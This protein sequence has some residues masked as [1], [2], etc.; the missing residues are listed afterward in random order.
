MNR[1]LDLF[2]N[3]LLPAALL[4]TPLIYASSTWAADK[5]E[6][7]AEAPTE[8]SA[9]PEAAGEGANFICEADVFFSWKRTPPPR[10]TTDAQGKT[11]PVAVDPELLKPIEE[12]FTKVGESG[13]IE[14]DVRNRLATRL[15]GVELQAR[16][17]C[18]ELHQDRVSCVSRN[19]RTTKSDYQLLDFAA[20][21]ALLSSIERECEDNTGVCLSTRTGAITCFLNTPPDAA[22]AGA[23][24]G[25]S[26]K[27][28][29]KKK[30]KK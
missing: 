10:T 11:V 14:N 28:S 24:G 7:T 27:E 15:G 23:A 1:S 3:L 30:G 17:S 4:L 19:L 18:E 25:E 12:F 21:K 16:R 29:D 26:A 2:K 5:E 13:K 20:R 6:K 22:A 9:P 8:T